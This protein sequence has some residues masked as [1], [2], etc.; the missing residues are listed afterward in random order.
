MALNIL[1]DTNIFINVKNKE[2][3]YYTYS[4]ALLDEIDEGILKGIISTVVVAEI[5]SAYHTSRELKEKHEFLTHILT[6][7]NY[8][9][10]D[11]T[12]KIADEAGHIRAK[13]GLKLPDAL[14]IAS[15]LKEKADCII[16]HDNL[17]RKANMFIKTASAKEIIERLKK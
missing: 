2:A 4:K 12:V 16:T 14:I 5:C 7:P 15:G 13:T 17:L 3:P 10:V 8:K 11:V 1:I 9:I 6:S